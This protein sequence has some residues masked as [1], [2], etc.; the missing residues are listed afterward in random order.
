MWCCNELNAGYA[1]DGYARRKGVG[2]CVVTFC[3]GG[4]SV[5]N[6]IAG[7]Y[8]EDLP[9]I[10]ISGAPN[11]ND[12]AT[13]RTL[14]HTTQAPEF[15]QQLRCFRGVCVP[16]RCCSHNHSHPGALSVIV[17]SS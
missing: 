17:S 10:V 1:A 9:V 14:H 2:C 12:W 13:N 5:I 8:A 16:P 4:L 3:V 7:A 6:A 15:G 11:S